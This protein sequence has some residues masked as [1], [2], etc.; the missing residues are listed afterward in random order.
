MKPSA[1][2]LSSGVVAIS[3]CFNA[4]AVERPPMLPSAKWSVTSDNRENIQRWRQQKD[5]AS[6]L[7]QYADKLLGDTPAMLSVRNNGG[8]PALV[9]FSNDVNNVSGDIAKLG[10]PI[11]SPF[12]FCTGV[13]SSLSLFWQAALD[14]KPESELRRIMG[15]YQDSQEACQEQINTAPE[16]TYRV[17]GPE[18]EATKL[19]EG[20]LYIFDV[21]GNDKSGLG[22][23]TCR[24]SLF[25]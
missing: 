16:L 15:S 19:P 24:A 5:D 22:T 11:T 21:T 7:I 17:K 12:S 18:S 25:K 14:R 20:C 4:V 10:L 2:L 1:W 23:W 8:G 6:F 3:M 13:G 9:A